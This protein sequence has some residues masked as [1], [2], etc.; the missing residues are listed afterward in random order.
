MNLERILIWSDDTE[1][2]RKFYT[3]FFAGRAKRKATRQQG[4]SDSFAIAFGNG[5]ALDVNPKNRIADLPQG[6][7]IVHPT[8]NLSFRFE[9][10]S[11]V[12]N[13]TQWIVDEGHRLEQPPYHLNNGCYKSVVRDPD[14]NKIEIFHQD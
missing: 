1:K 14:H 9:N 10:R 8:N 13:L 11:Q 12:D 4:Q 3:R 5:P 2:T 6:T 7:P